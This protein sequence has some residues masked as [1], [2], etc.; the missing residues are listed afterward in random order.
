M[1]SLTI[2]II[3]VALSLDAFAVSI[4]CGLKLKHLN[5]KKY[6]KIALFFGAF[7]ALMPILGW[8]LGHLIKNFFI[9]YANI[10]AFVI[11]LIL[12]TKT[13]IQSI[14]IDSK[15]NENNQCSS[16]SETPCTCNNL[17]CLLSLSVAT[18]I[19]AFL[20]GPIL[21][22]YDLNILIS[23]LVIGVV[24]FLICFCGPLL[25][26][27]LGN[28]FGKKAELVAGIILI[29]IAFKTLFGK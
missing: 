15:K 10:I 12:G 28:V 17:R 27:R 21:A 26:N 14:K 8:S 19:D 1:S 23:V 5:Y 9:N 18:S 22:L 7:Q 29:A 20:I 16:E 25:G 13:L 6:F 24:T 2:F 11:F 3:A 4:S